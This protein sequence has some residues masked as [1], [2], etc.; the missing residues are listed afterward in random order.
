MN[1]KILAILLIGSA[2]VL[3]YLGSNR[4]FPVDT[5]K[6]AIVSSNNTT[7]APASAS[8]G[9]TLERRTDEQGEVN[10]AVQPIVVRAGVPTQ[11]EISMDTH[12]VELDADVTKQAVLYDDQSRLYKPVSWA[13]AGPGGHHRSGTLTFDPPTT[14][15]KSIELQMNDVG[16]IPIRTFRWE[17]SNR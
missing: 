3:V 8:N 9:S 6:P 7:T 17:I 4:I 2:A 15:P 12:S 13:G 14:M 5:A 16:G 10:V 11:F 1:T